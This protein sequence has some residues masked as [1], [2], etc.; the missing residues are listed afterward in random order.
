MGKKKSN[1]NGYAKMRAST[2]ARISIVSVILRK[3]QH[4][5]CRFQMFFNPDPM[6]LRSATAF[7]SE[8]RRF[9]ARDLHRDLTIE[10]QR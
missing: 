4:H 9:L 3:S 8:T 10:N 7:G 6:P 1:K 5:S 2:M